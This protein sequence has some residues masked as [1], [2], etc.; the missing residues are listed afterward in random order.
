ME[1]LAGQVAGNGQ[2]RR[3]RT[4]DGHFAAR[5]FWDAFV[6]QLHVGVKLR[7]E[8][9]QFADSDGAPLLEMCIRDSC[10]SLCSQSEGREGWG[11]SFAP[12]RG[13]YLG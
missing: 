12:E 5:L 9:L 8:A 2:S 11:D 10:S 3:T 4:D 13:S 7:D 1:A 6:R